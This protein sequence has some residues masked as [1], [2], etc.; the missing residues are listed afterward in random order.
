MFLTLMRRAT[1]SLLLLLPLF[2]QADGAGIL[3]EQCAACH[4]MER[5]DFEALGKSERLQR[6]APPL[7]YAGNKYR[8][9]WLKS[10]LQEPTR[11]YPVG[12]FP[13][14]A[15]TSTPEGDMPDPSALQ[16]HMKLE[17]E[18]AGQVATALMALRPHDDLIESD[19]YTPG[20]VS[21]RMGMMDFRKFK[22]CNACHQDAIDEG[23]LSGPVVYNA[24]ERLQPA[25]ISSFVQNP[26][27]WDP[28]TIMPVPQMNEAAVHKLVN[29]LKVIGGEQ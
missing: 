23:G 5:P 6:Q 8:P 11:I 20:S 26:R 13:Q 18:A 28:N 10:W 15:V 29:Y 9:E 7:Y 22:G 25:F 27:A 19:N 16:E 4:A 21:P 3:K 14:L 17:P 24:W 12:Y 1:C 2:V